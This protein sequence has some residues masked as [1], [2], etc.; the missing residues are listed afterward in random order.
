MAINGTAAGGGFQLRHFGF[1]SQR[2]SPR[3]YGSDNR[4][5]ATYM[6]PRFIGVRRAKELMLTKRRDCRRT[7]DSHLQKLPK[8]KFVPSPPDTGIRRQTPARR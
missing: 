7:V 8:R 1:N 6:L 2:N 5:T 3:L 4:R